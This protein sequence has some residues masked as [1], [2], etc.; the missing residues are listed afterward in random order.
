MKSINNKKAKKAKKTQKVKTA[1]RCMLLE[2]EDDSWADDVVVAPAVSIATRA[3]ADLA[4][5]TELDADMPRLSG[6]RS[7]LEQF[8]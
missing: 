8:S 3:R 6:P 1:E 5:L 2:L 7:P 4:A